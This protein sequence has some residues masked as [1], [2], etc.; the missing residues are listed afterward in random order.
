MRLLHNEFLQYP[1]TAPD[2]P[3]A[4]TVTAGTPVNLAVVD[5]ITAAV[6]EVAEHT[7]SVNPDAGPLPQ[8]VADVYDWYRQHTAHADDTQRQRG[9]TI[10][11]RQRLEHAIAMGDD[12]VIPPHR[13]PA[14]RT[15]GL[16]WRRELQRALCTNRRCLTRHGMSRTWTLARLA[17]E[18]VAV[19]K[20]SREC[21]T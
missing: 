10:V 6:T 7:R 4:R 15:F 14:C 16:R 21:A 5:H 17:Y 3:R 9:E 13:C 8:D 12:S 11:Y 19:E 1:R 2:G 20:M 18:H